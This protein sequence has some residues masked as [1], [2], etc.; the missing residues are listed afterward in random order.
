MKH[1]YVRR[2]HTVGSLEDKQN[3]TG[4][5]QVALSSEEGTWTLV[6]HQGTPA[7]HGA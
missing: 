4:K 7:A 5:A 3:A 2:E 6:F 1:Y